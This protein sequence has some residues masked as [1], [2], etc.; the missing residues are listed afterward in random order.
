MDPS[1]NHV[2]SWLSNALGHLVTSPLLWVFIACLLGVLGC[3]WGLFRHAQFKRPADVTSENGPATLEFVLI[4]PMLLFCTLTL[5]QTTLVMGGNIFVHYS[6]FAATR[7]AIT[8]IPLNYTDQGEPRNYLVLPDGQKAQRI[9]QAATFAL[10]PVA[11]RLSDSS[12]S[13]SQLLVEGFKS[14]YRD[15]NQEPPVWIDNFLAARLAYANAHTDITFSRAVTESVD[16]LA[17]MTLE[18]GVHQFG[19]REPITVQ[20]EHQLNLAV[21]YVWPL[22][23][24]STAARHTLVKAYYTLNNEGIDIE[25]PPSP[26]RPLDFSQP[27]P[28]RD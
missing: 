7:S 21:P 16:D 1:T 17:M 4:I 14:Y 12:T 20:V 11:G 26:R 28:R 27:L 5:A 9:R 2:E 18:A 10:L 13:E 24:D 22:F 6:A 3:L 19:P 8:T 23:A 25:L 15:L